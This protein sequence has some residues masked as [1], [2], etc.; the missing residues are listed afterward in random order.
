MLAVSETS[1]Q[2]SA[3]THRHMVS[4]GWGLYS[5]NCG[6]VADVDMLTAE[7]GAVVCNISA[8]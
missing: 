6:F 4:K 7:R 8:V 1:E 2:D 5:Q 3:W